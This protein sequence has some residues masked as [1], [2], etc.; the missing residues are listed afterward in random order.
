M[1]LLFWPFWR[2]VSCR[3]EL[4]SRKQKQTKMSLRDVLPAAPRRRRKRDDAPVQPRQVKYELPPMD[5]KVKLLPKDFATANTAAQL[6]QLFGPQ[7]ISNNLHLSEAASRDKARQIANELADAG[8]A[9][10]YA[11]E[12][13]RQE[14]GG[15]ENKADDGRKI[16]AT[17]TLADD[18]GEWET[19]P[20]AELEN[21]EASLRK[22]QLEALWNKKALSGTEAVLA[23]MALDAAVQAGHQ[24][25]S[26]LES[27]ALD[28][29][30]GVTP[31][32]E[33][34]EL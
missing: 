22:E 15:Q 31:D 3:N 20:A 12:V 8:V 30:N 33:R 6:M 27:R 9:S 4:L 29:L 32:K 24:S 14:I 5:S 16:M 17:K 10:R 18:T 26:Y 7:V 11:S 34:V 25:P 23:L 2:I 21:E 13:L 28:M 19:K 1:L